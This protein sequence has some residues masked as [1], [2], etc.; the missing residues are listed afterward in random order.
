MTLQ[1]GLNIL[2]IESGGNDAIVASLIEAI[3]SYIE[4]TTGLAEEKQEEEPLVKVASQFILT[5]WYY[6][7]RVDE[8]SINR[9]IEAILKAIT[10]K[11]KNETDRTGN[12]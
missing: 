6:G 3:P 8:A 1:E 9:T 2:R 5:L 10:A 4:T 12:I 11:V 7:E